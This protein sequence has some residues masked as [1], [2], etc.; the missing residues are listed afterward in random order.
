MER[1]DKIYA[2]KLDCPGSFDKFDGVANRGK[3]LRIGCKTGHVER[4]SKTSIGNNN[5][6]LRCFDQVP[7][8]PPFATYHPLFYRGFFIGKFP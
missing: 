3:W 6:N 7:A 5:S 4:K 8:S 1:I 2:K